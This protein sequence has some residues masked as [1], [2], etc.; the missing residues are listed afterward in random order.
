M[1][2]HD[3]DLLRA[4]SRAPRAP[5]DALGAEVGLSGN[6]VKARL[7]KLREDGALQGVVALPRPARLGLREGLLVFEG[8]HDAPER[9]D[10]LLRGLPE[11]PGVRF[12]DVG[13]DAIHLHVLFAS[14]ADWER[15]ERAAI[16]FVGKP[17]THRAQA[18]AQDAA[19]L[20]PA[21]ARVADALLADARRPLNDIADAAHLSTKTARRRLDAMLA[22]GDLR[23]EPVLSP[24]EAKGL[25]VGLFVVETSAPSF[26]PP[27]AVTLG[28]GGLVT[29]LLA[30]PT[31]RALHAE[32]KAL[33]AT[34]GVSRVF[35]L[36]G[37]RRHAEGW[38]R[39]ALARPARGVPPE[40]IAP[41][42]PRVRG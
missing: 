27:D 9:E 4:L 40:P 18:P 1:D 33:R 36:V 2:A 22:R 8:V 6:A 10:E 20:S 11:V 7:A 34:P 19:P 38:L 30:R 17:P 16:S 41:A 12:A 13:P 32:A 5:A 28:E 31:P 3:L 29:L 35:P 24:A 21:D 39:D 25:A 15:I 42:A 37:T 23:L 14:D 26:L